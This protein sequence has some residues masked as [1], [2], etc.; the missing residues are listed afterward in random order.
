MHTPPAAGSKIVIVGAG[1]FGLSTAYALST[2]KKY[3]IWVY[4]RDSIPIPDAASTDIN[5]AVRVEYGENAIYTDLML[6]ALPVWREWNEERK[7]QG[8]PPVYNETGVLMLGKDGKFSS[9][10]EASMRL[11]QE[12]G[13]G[14]SLE[15]LDAEAIKTRFPVFG[16]AV[17]AGYDKACFNHQGGWCH[18]SEA[19]IHLYQKCVANGVHFVLGPELGSFTHL[20]LAGD[21]VTGIRTKDGEVHEADLVVMATGAW[22]PALLRDMNS[23]LLA[24]GQTVVQF[25]LPD[26]LNASL[27]ATMPVWCANITETGMYG[28]PPNAD[29]KLKVARHSFGFG[30]LNPEDGISVPRTHSTHSADTIPLSALKRTRAFL[31]SFFPFTSRLNVSYARVCWYCD[32]VDGDFLVAPHPKWSNLIVAAGD[33][34]HGMKF[35]PVIGFNICDVIESRETVYTKRWAYR[36]YSEEEREALKGKTTQF[37]TDEGNA[38]ASMATLDE[39]KPAI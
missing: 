12:R 20:E 11:L 1:A 33:S 22:T 3:D 31:D 8:L 28:F 24:T 36:E 23:A 18:S 15:E 34:G 19:I 25:V 30:Y 16:D 7:V 13:H 38:E 32:T 26:D 21:K 37:L 10:E 2:K 14:G 5:K 29:G 9:Y 35:L 27:S 17:K 39:L 4:D 6:S